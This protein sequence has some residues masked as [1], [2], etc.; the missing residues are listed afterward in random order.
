MIPAHSTVIHTGCGTEG[1]GKGWV[2]GIF[3]LED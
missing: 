2:S 1:E 3:R